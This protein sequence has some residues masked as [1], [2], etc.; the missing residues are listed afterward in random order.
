MSDRGHR[1]RAHV[2]LTPANRYPSRLPWL[3]AHP[4]Y[5]LASPRL[6]GARF[7]QQLLIVENRLDG[8]AQLPFDV[9]QFFFVLRGAVTL[10]VAGE[11]IELEQGGYVYARP[12]APVTLE[13]AAAAE[14]VR[15]S[16]TWTPADGQEPPPDLVG[17]LGDH[18]PQETGVPG[19]TRR[20]LLPADDPAAD[21][22]MSVMHFAPEAELGMVE[23][24]DE[25]HGLLMLAG[26]GRYLLD[27]AWHDVEAGDF[28]Y[29]GPYCPQG[30]VA[31]G[32]GSSYLLYK[33]VFRE[34]P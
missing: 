17:H 5:K 22:T 7:S 29:L 18:P 32:E 15:V 13:Q 10:T 33:D 28:I 31:G 34:E 2:L 9:E 14:L 23:I 21:F 3:P 8:P 25:E 1:G 6:L 4:V 19:L 24:H 30:F 27:D 16:R 26:S 12:D 20:E 11:R